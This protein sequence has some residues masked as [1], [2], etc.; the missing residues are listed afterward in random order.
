MTTSPHNN[1]L[2]IGVDIGGTFTDMVVMD[3]TGIVEV[4]KVL[5]TPDEPARGVEQVIRETLGKASINPADV[6]GFVHGTTLVTNALIERKGVRTALLATAGF[7]DVLELHREHRYDLYDLMLELPRPL[8]PRWLRFDVPE[9][10][11]SDGSVAEDLD[12]DY[13]ERLTRELVEN[14]VEAVAIVFLHS[15]KNPAH[16]QQTREIINRIAPHIR[17]AISSEVVPEIREYERASTTV[18]NVYVQGLTETYLNDLRLRSKDVGLQYEPHIMLSNGGVATIDTAGAFP[19]R[20]LESGPAGGALAAAAFGKAADHK[21]LLAFDMGG[22]TAKLCMIADSEP[23]ISHHFEV[24]RVYRMKAG[25]GLPVNIPVID[26]I[27]IGVGGGSIARINEL[28]LLTVG[29]DSAGSV[30]GPVCYGRGGTLPTVTDADLVLGYLDPNYFLGGAMTLDLE[31]AREAIDEQIAK[32]LGVT[33]EQA[34][35]GIHSSVNENMANAARVHAIERGMDPEGQPMFTSGG[36]GPV[37]GAG[38]ARALGAPQVVCAPAAGVMSAVGFL[39]APLSFDFVR[40]S[41]VLVDEIGSDSEVEDLFNEMESE[42]TRILRESGLPEAEIQHHRFAEVRYEGQG[43]EI[44]VPL[45]ATSCNWKTTIAQAF[46]EHYEHLYRREGLD[47]PAEV[48]TWRVVTSGPTPEVTLF[49][50][51]MR[52]E[53]SALVAK[54]TRHAYFSESDGYVATPVF[55]R[56]TLRP[57]DRIEGPAIIEERESTLIATPNSLCTVAPDGALVV[58][59]NAADA[60]SNIVDMEEVSA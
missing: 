56:Y 7:S 60:G 22:T 49:E 26:M 44:R 24:D 5:T 2:R 32:P 27:E 11:Y 35:Y 42:G 58:H 41:H 45:P 16:E 54:G 55:D 21:N 38:V 50:K 3:D 9:R 14:D 47:L 8:A 33:V 34:A 36:A 37:H 46:R 48:L 43:F 29:P 4:G 28:G 23:L 15:Y 19:I 53:G 25:S 1:G 31:G 39:T 57:G 12:V 17:V 6:V 18:A 10:I 52:P 13:V 59:L 20:M 51:R 40:S 30:P